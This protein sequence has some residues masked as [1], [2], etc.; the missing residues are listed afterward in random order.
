MNII[1]EN[2]T[3]MQEKLIIRQI[4]IDSEGYKEELKLR[5][6]VLRKP[7]K[8]NLF[9]E[10]L[11]SEKNDFHIGAF[12]S[13]LLVGVL[14][15]TVLNNSEIKMRQ[16]AV[17]ESYKGKSIGTKLVIYAEDFAKRLGYKKIVLNS[18]KTAVKFYEK[19]G[20]VKI[21]E[22]FI[23]VTIPHYKMQKKIS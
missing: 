18:R 5:D 7:L 3:N 10:N 11:E 17:S 20:Y 6:R 14:I 13:D 4:K 2:L 23:E 15:L 9:D 8:L 21:G 1:I 22:E 12:L 19:L 16:V